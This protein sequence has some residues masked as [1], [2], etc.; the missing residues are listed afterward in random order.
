MEANA[1]RAAR[2]TGGVEK[3]IGARG[4]EIVMSDVGIVGPVIGRQ[5]AVGGSRITSQ[6]ISDQRLAIR[7]I[8]KG[9]AN[10]AMRKNGVVKIE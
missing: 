1:I 10:F 3:R 5:Q 6:K 2:K 7:G 8:G 9:L 4:I